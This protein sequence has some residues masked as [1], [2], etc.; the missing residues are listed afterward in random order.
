MEKSFIIDFTNKSFTE[1]NQKVI[2]KLLKVKS[3]SQIH[4]IDYIYPLKKL[5]LKIYQI[6][7]HINLSGYNPLIGPSFISLTNI[8]NCKNGIV[9]V[10]LPKNIEPNKREKKVLLKSGVDAICYNL[11]PTAILAAALNLKI[12][13]SGILKLF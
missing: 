6:K 8:Y 7:D 1:Y 10:A 4:I 9:V 5:K 3:K 2:N 11:V 13:A 12:K